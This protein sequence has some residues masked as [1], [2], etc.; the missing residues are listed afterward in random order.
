MYIELNAINKTYQENKTIN[1]MPLTILSVSNP[2]PVESLEME[3]KV[4]NWNRII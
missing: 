1:S 4:T 3:K 2:F